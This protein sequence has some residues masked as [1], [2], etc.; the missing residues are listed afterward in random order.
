MRVKDQ[1]SFLCYLLDVNETVNP[2]HLLVKA[3]TQL[4]PLAIRVRWKSVDYHFEIS[5]HENLR[6]GKKKR[7]KGEKQKERKAD[8]EKEGASFTS[9]GA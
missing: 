2:R 6:A 5:F 3:N 7:K 1:V 8:T 4:P 9:E